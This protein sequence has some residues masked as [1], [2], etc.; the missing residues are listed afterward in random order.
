MMFLRVGQ[1]GRPQW[2]TGCG[3]GGHW[4]QKVWPDRNLPRIFRIVRHEVSGFFCFFL[5]YHV[6]TFSGG[7]AK[8]KIEGIGNKVGIW[9]VEIG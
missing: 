1:E 9:G 8:L 2:Q 7:S 4:G 6:L 5:A 3:F